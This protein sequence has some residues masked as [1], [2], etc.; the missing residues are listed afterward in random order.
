MLCDVDVLFSVYVLWCA[1]VLPDRFI[2]SYDCSLCLF[3]MVLESQGAEP[4]A[5]VRGRKLQHIDTDIHIII[6]CMLYV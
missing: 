4:E 2:S 1:L 3:T 5:H 6:V